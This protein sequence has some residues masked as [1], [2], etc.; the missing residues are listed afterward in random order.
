MRIIG[1]CRP[2]PNED[3]ENWNEADFTAILSNF[4]ENE[5]H[6][7]HS[8]YFDDGANEEGHD[9]FK[10]LL[11]HIKSS[12][13]AFLI[14]VPDSRHLVRELEDAARVAIEV[15]SLKSDL[16]CLDE[17]Y[18][19]FLQNSAAYIPAPGVSIQKSNN[20]RAAMK[21]RA[22]TGKSL[23]KPPYGY[24]ID[25]SGKFVPNIREAKIV[26]EIF[27]LYVDDDF[28]LRRIAQTLNKQ[29]IRSRSG[30]DWNIITLRDILKNTTCIGTYSRFGLRL[31]NNHEP[32][33]QSDLF[34]Q[35]QDKTRSRRKYRSFIKSEPYLL[36]GLCRCG[37]CGNSMV[38]VSTKQSWQSLSGV[39]SVNH[40]RYY[41]CQSKNNQE[42]CG[43]HT[44]ASAKLE[45]KVLDTIKEQSFSKV[46]KESMLG[47]DGEYKRMK[48]AEIRFLK[49]ANAEKRFISFFR[50]T[51]AGKSVLERLKLY[52]DELDSCRAQAFL[53]VDAE[54]FDKF[55]STWDTQN[56][57][58]KQAFLNEYVKQVI[59]KDR[60]V[61][62]L[63]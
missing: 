45:T 13:S 8:I 15:N 28:G 54:D 25:H 1:F 34:R 51:A 37:Y 20:I 39:K 3:N 22:I 62:V 2:L 29:E 23:G 6:V 55:I 59:V 46:M 16:I 49:V 38:G 41:K 33:I 11:S 32:I 52:L 44:W 63:L 36:S 4:A 14:A 31:T 53:T 57:A 58:K 21:K 24:A 48:A 40:Y 19:D 42:I 26:Q 47:V 5:R 27:R 35:A 12:K 17:E 56:F 10:E 30:K 9:G 61:R 18:P 43:Y 50:K 7:I 60:S